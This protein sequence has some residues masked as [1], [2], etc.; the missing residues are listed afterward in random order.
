MGVEAFLSFY[1]FNIDFPA[2]LKISCNVTKA[3]LNKG[4]REINSFSNTSTYTSKLVSLIDNQN[5]RSLVFTFH[6]DTSNFSSFAA[7]LKTFL[8]RYITHLSEFYDY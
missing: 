4:K 6:R 2:Y 8:Q 5:F 7:H 1:D 3:F